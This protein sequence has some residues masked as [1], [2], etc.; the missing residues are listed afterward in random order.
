MAAEIKKKDQSEVKSLEKMT[1]K[2]LR[3]LALEIPRSVAVT[4]M[5]KDELIALLKQSRG[6]EDEGAKK[7][8]K[9]ETVKA[10]RTKEELKA[11][12]RLLKQRRIDAQEKHD[13][14]SADRLR[15]RIS[16]LKKRTRKAA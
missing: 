8:E 15:R 12:I 6:E 7:K 14:K 9:K 11:T 3:A 1:V 4:D 16:R 2:E 13:K 5:K 10:V